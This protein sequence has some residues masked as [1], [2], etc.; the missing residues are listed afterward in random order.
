MERLNASNLLTFY[1]FCRSNDLQILTHRRR[2]RDLAY[3]CED[4]NGDTEFPADQWLKLMTYLQLSDQQVHYADSG[5]QVSTYSAVRILAAIKF[6][7]RERG[8]VTTPQASPGFYNVL[9][10]PPPK[11]SQPST[12]RREGETAIPPSIF[13]AIRKLPDN[14][15]AA[16]IGQILT[17]EGLVPSGP[18]EPSSEAP[19]GEHSLSL[20]HI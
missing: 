16:L 13:E 5:N 17:R 19:P 10:S 9:R 11:L 7:L 1:Q 18:V 6:T 8:L 20:I 14:E 2:A 4:D 12:T 3:Q 15:R